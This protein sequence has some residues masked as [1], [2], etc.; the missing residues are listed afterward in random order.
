MKSD[1]LSRVAA[2]GLQVSLVLGH[3]WLALVE[4]VKTWR[5]PMDGD[6]SKVKMWRESVVARR[7]RRQRI[8][9]LHWC[10]L[11]LLHIHRFPVGR[12]ECD[13]SCR[14]QTNSDPKQES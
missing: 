6:D 7:V 12:S 3:S 8:R 9:L 10:E 4:L 13:P 2:E 14:Q 5:A 1:S 11:L